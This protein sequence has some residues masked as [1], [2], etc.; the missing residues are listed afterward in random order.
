MSLRSVIGRVRWF[1][2]CVAAIL[3]SI[4]AMSSSLWAQTAT[5]HLHKDAS[6][7]TGLFQLKVPGPDATSLAIQTIDLK[8]KPTGEY[9]IKQFDTQSGVPN[10][11]GYIPSGSLV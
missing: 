10:A 4:G 3:L 9:V 11:G 2:R 1:A 8:N 6:S 7:T 5:Y